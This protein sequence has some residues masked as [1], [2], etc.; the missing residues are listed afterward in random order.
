MRNRIPL[1]LWPSGGCYIPFVLSLL[2]GHRVYFAGFTLAALA[3]RLAFL[4]H[5]PSITDDSRVYADFATNWLQHGTYAETQNGKI[6]PAD[7]RLPGYPAFMAFVFA[8]FGVGNYRAVML[9]QVLLDLCT[10]LIIADLV[11]RTVS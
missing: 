6:V 9:V 5:Y 8:L 3:L 2:R 11:R 10:C 7:T 1:C 4:F